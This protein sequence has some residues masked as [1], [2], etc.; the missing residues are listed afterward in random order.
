LGPFAPSITLLNLRPSAFRAAPRGPT[1]LAA[2]AGA[3][4]AKRKPSGTL[5]SYRDTQAAHTTFTVVQSQPGV[6]SGARCIPPPKH[7]RRGAKR[8]RR[9]VTLGSFGHT[10][11][12]G[13]NRL[14]FSGRLH[15]RKLKPGFYL[16]RAEARNSAGLRSLR[17][18][19]E[20]RIIR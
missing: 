14:R 12:V 7:P 17:L 15:G 9:V 4:K 16:L 6:R 13:F 11:V 8:C 1:A 19:R 5:I 18:A 2:K 20:F 10:D 3:A